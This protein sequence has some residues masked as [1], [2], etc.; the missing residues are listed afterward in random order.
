MGKP[1]VEYATLEAL[2]ELELKLETFQ[3]N[4]SEQEMGFDTRSQKMEKSVQHL[5]DDMNNKIRS[6]EDKIED[7]RSEI[8]R[9]QEAGIETNVIIEREASRITENDE[10]FQQLQQQ[11]EGVHSVVDQN[12][13]IFSR[14]QKQVQESLHT[15]MHQIKKDLQDFATNCASTDARTVETTLR[16]ILERAVGDARDR[17]TKGDHELEKRL[18]A[19]LQTAVATLEQ[20]LSTT[21]STFKEECSCISTSS[22]E[23][24]RAVNDEI[25]LEISRVDTKAKERSSKDYR[26]LEDARMAQESLLSAQLRK[27]EIESQNTCRSLEE[28][29]KTNHSDFE[30][31]CLGAE[32][33]IKEVRTESKASL[34]SLV[35]DSEQLSAICAGVSGLPTRQVEWRLS[36]DAL[37]QIESF[38]KLD[39]DDAAVPEFGADQ[40]GG[41]FSPS[42]EAAGTRGMQ[43]ELRLQ[44]S[45]SFE[46]GEQCSLYLWAAEG[47][48]LVFRLFLGTESVVLRHTFDG[49]LPCGMKNMGTIGE[50]C[51]P[52]GSLHLGIEI[53]ESFMESSV[54]E[55]HTALKVVQREQINTPIQGVLSVQ[56]YLNHRLLELVQS[57]ARSMVDQLHKK[58]DLVRS[59]A[60]RKVQWRLENGPLL[61]RSFPQNQAVRSTAFQAAGVNGLQ[62]VFYPQGYAGAR[63]GFCSVFVHVPPGCA[64]VR[65]WLWAGRWRREAKAEEPPDKPDLIGRI[66]FCRFEN[67]V[68][69]TDDAVELTL[70]IEE[71]HLQGSEAPPPGT[72]PKAITQGP[73]SNLD[74]CDLASM[75]VQQNNSMKPS[76]EAVQQLPAIWTTQ[77]FHTFADAVASQGGASGGALV[78]TAT[79]SLTDISPVA[80]AGG[81]RPNSRNGSRKSTPR[82]CSA[83]GGAHSREARFKE[84]R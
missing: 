6:L 31:Y 24:V 10:R 84:Y 8:Q 15:E 26:N 56:R 7:Q 22:Q 4:T 17:A 68:D 30:Q 28:Q 11:L 40:R 3:A 61:C 65:C 47:L 58:V 45:E 12:L 66:N 25:R 76:A 16:A 54:S 20:D 82:S 71:V 77:A 37:R 57:Q 52:D 60:T 35:H 69:P 14:M 19:S 73:A 62:L 9:L 81:H 64:R 48:Q 2:L 1:K 72:D 79:P 63:A 39:T 67:C 46:D 55:T 78:P 38:G 34:Q 36:Q 29:S 41:I 42:F 83:R 5:R 49:R 23:R 44:P 27:L 43:L 32:E 21:K 80:A 74:R 51:S 50:Q 75:K 18:T 59:R 70:E 33:R 13:E 53:H